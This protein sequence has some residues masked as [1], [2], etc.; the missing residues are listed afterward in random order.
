MKNQPNKPKTLY[1]AI[2]RG[3]NIGFDEL[4]NSNKRLFSITYAMRLTVK[5]LK[6]N[7][8]SLSPEIREVRVKKLEQLHQKLFTITNSTRINKDFT[9]YLES[10]QISLQGDH[11]R[12]ESK[13]NKQNEKQGN[14]VDATSLRRIF[15][16]AVD[17]NSAN[18]VTEVCRIYGN[19]SKDTEKAIFH[20]IVSA[21]YK[22]T[23][24]DQAKLQYNQQLK[25]AKEDEK[26]KAKKIQVLNVLYNNLSSDD[27]RRLNSPV[28]LN[29]R[30]EIKL[31][32]SQNRLLSKGNVASEVDKIGKEL[33]STAKN[34]VSKANFG[35]PF[36][37][38][39]NDIK[40]PAVSSKAPPNQVSS[41]QVDFNKAIEISD[42]EEVV[43]V[44][45]K[46]KDAGLPLDVLDDAYGTLAN[47]DE[48]FEEAISLME[49][50]IEQSESQEL[51]SDIP[52]E[53][54][55]GDNDLTNPD[56]RDDDFGSGI[57]DDLN[58][59]QSS[60][61]A[62]SPTSELEALAIPEG[63]EPLSR[64]QDTTGAMGP[65]PASPELVNSTTSNPNSISDQS[66]APK[67]NVSAETLS[68]TTTIPLTGQPIQAPDAVVPLNNPIDSTV[69]N[70]EASN[71]TLPHV[72]EPAVA[73]SFEPADPVTPSLNSA[74]AEV[75]PDTNPAIQTA[76][77][78]DI[79]PLNSAAIS[80]ELANPVT[81]NDI[82]AE[83]T[84][85]T[86]VILDTSPSGLAVNN[87]E[88][89]GISSQDPEPATTVVDVGT[90]VDLPIAND[91]QSQK[92]VL[93][94]DT[95]DRRAPILAPQKK[96]VLTRIRDA[97]GIYQVMEQEENL[98]EIAQF[99]TPSVTI[100]SDQAITQQLNE[101]IQQT[102]P[103]R[104]V[105]AEK[106]NTVLEP[107]PNTDLSELSDE[108][109]KTA[110]EFATIVTGKGK[111]KEKSETSKLSDDIISDNNLNK[112]NEL[113]MQGKSVRN[114]KNALT[115]AINAENVADATNAAL[116]SHNGEDYY[117][118]A[119][120]R[121]FLDLQNSIGGHDSE[122]SVKSKMAQ[123]E[124][125]A[126]VVELNHEKFRS[127]LVSLVNSAKAASDEQTANESLEEIKDFLKIHE[128][129]EDLFKSAVGNLRVDLSDSV[130]KSAKSS[131]ETPQTQRVKRITELLDLYKGKPQ[132]S[133]GLLNVYQFEKAVE[134]NIE[135][136]TE[137]INSKSINTA[138]NKLKALLSK[139]KD[140][141]VGYQL[142]IGEKKGQYP[143]T[144]MP[145]SL[146]KGD[147]AGRAINTGGQ[148]YSDLKKYHLGKI[149]NEAS[150]VASIDSQVSTTSTSRKTNSVAP[151]QP[152]A[153]EQNKLVN[154]EVI[155]TSTNTTI[156][157]AI[158]TVAN[159]ASAV[160]Q[161][162]SN[163]EKKEKKEKKEKEEK[164]QDGTSNVLITNGN[165]PVFPVVN[166]TVLASTTEEVTQDLVKLPDTTGASTA[167][168]N[169]AAAGNLQL[170]T[171]KDEL[172]NKD[173]GLN[174]LFGYS[175]EEKGKEKVPE[176]EQKE[177]E[178]TSTAPNLLDENAFK[179][180]VK[181][182]LAQLNKNKRGLNG[183]EEFRKDYKDEFEEYPTIKEMFELELEHIKNYQIAERQNRGE[184]TS[185][186][187]KMSD[188]ERELRKLLQPYV[189]FIIRYNGSVKVV[190]ESVP[191]ES[192]EE[193]RAV[194]V[195]EKSVTGVNQKTLEAINKV[196]RPY[197]NEP[198]AKQVEA[199]FY[200]LNVGTVAAFKQKAEKIPSVIATNNVPNDTLSA[201]E[202]SRRNGERGKIFNNANLSENEGTLNAQQRGRNNGI[203]QNPLFEQSQQPE[204]HDD[205]EFI[206]NLFN[207]GAPPPINTPDSPP[208]L[209]QQEVHDEEYE[210]LLELAKEPSKAEKFI[211]REA[212][213]NVPNDGDGSNSGRKSLIRTALLKITGGNETDYNNST[214]TAAKTLNK[215]VDLILG[216]IWDEK[217]NKF[218]RKNIEDSE[219]NKV[220]QD[221]AA[222]IILQAYLY[223][224][225]SFGFR[226]LDGGRFSSKEKENETYLNSKEE[227]YYTDKA[228]KA[229]EN[230]DITARDIENAFKFE[231]RGR[232]RDLGRTMASP[233]HFLLEAPFNI[234]NNLYENKY[235]ALGAGTVGLLIASAFIPG[236]LPLVV[237]IMASAW[238][239]V[240]MVEGANAMLKNKVGKLPF[241]AVTLVAEIIFPG[242]V[243]GIAVGLDLAMSAINK[244]LGILG[245]KP[246]PHPRIKAAVD[247]ITPAFGEATSYINHYGDKKKEEP[248]RKF[249][250]NFEGKH[251]KSL[252]Y[253]E[254]VAKDDLRKE[255]IKSK[256]KNLDYKN[257]P[258][259]LE[260]AS[261]GKYLDEGTRTALAAKIINGLRMERDKTVLAEALK[262]GSSFARYIGAADSDIRQEFEQRRDGRTI[263][264][265][266]APA[267][268]RPTVAP[269]VQQ[270]VAPAP[271][272]DDSGPIIKAYNRAREAAKAATS[273]VTTKAAS[274]WNAGKSWYAGSSVP[275]APGVT[276]VMPGVPANPV[277]AN[278][279]APGTPVNTI[280][281]VVNVPLIGDTAAE[282]AALAALIGSTETTNSQSVNGN[283]GR[284]RSKSLT[285]PESRIKN[286]ATVDG[287]GSPRGK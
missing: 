1:E 280:T 197:S 161:S 131:V 70:P 285:S 239:G 230:G 76:D 141:G 152:Q 218:I 138:Q 128:N 14:W 29:K 75:V 254:A 66:P 191:N 2:T 30:G 179:D 59:T 136:V 46:Y 121:Y 190:T 216:K 132:T 272:K 105:L 282:A 188:K 200:T 39:P 252:N 174:S 65:E 193:K 226:V 154:K 243:K 74:L 181:T 32:K 229:F 246:I 103:E 120:R 271:E 95:I 287:N 80:P 277:A 104:L 116:K 78:L 199:E 69:S 259:A 260:N 142:V 139:H 61:D 88:P 111:S 156:D 55:S 108:A 237:A 51:S 118:A 22:R 151:I 126:Q 162:L 24:N 135:E 286:T 164:E 129:E 232:M 100:A 17:N 274:V 42:I 221:A 215:T 168:T 225:K 130:I 262:P 242:S 172:E 57:D 147:R 202:T 165:S 227:D 171:K 167:S 264:Q 183:T 83:A 209:Q 25:D 198:F 79:N 4:L 219:L 13:P 48:S 249:F 173:F 72:T 134:K 73:T 41:F 5:D 26:F 115:E 214:S 44:L 275:A 84:P 127:E 170:Q 231:G 258:K 273:G 148:P 182:F 19:R 217:K 213:E 50:I 144:T 98:R 244:A 228:V 149:F 16:S 163:V 166:T 203:T 270:P 234:M 90:K 27:K 107:T 71:A 77:V 119:V 189:S 187:Q 6:N 236:A 267:Q 94:D 23:F 101:P 283:S 109:K 87:P 247:K 160:N 43:R 81:P 255:E 185:T 54:S 9:K 67:V 211:T 114:F 235:K 36:G 140:E 222:K 263:P 194:F 278:T 233:L 12:L 52:T 268:Q 248:K 250:D 256:L 37:A 112:S 62:K 205:D 96:W 45:K 212:F 97:K 47:S 102:T 180:E 224:N 253:S 86:D 266:P 89:Q 196:F 245:I 145:E 40:L 123:L 220:I 7:K 110:V 178:V 18:D 60:D 53:L 35:N 133:N 177:K 113:P 99:T 15:K 56:L 106:P 206:N 238:L 28:E 21:A 122:Q 34:L 251:E 204:Q 31:L 265:N 284:P 159:E 207:D 11:V 175:N 63:E 8:I 201:R 153:S 257:L 169:Q 93:E 92:V 176:E 279:A 240:A 82:P 58:L 184:G 276:T 3:D 281:P 64:L 261:F 150:K 186:Q 91:K 124:I 210:E 143:V 38:K 85:V 125:L 223:K 10:C 195:Q 241:M 49:D 117:L 33:A 157:P 137:G 269:V 158:L 192:I 208:A 20:G 146:P 68:N 155:T